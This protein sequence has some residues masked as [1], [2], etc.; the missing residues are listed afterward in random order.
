MITKQQRGYGQDRP[1][2]AGAVCHK[3]KKLGHYASQCQLQGG[4][5][6]LCIYSRKFGHN[7]FV[8]Y[9]KQ[10]PNEYREKMQVCD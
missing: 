10:R 6:K 5:Q 2:R 3:C 8:C 9:T 4:G 7:E 1:T